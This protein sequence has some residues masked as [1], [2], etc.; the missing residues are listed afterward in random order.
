M[1]IISLVSVWVMPFLIAVILSYGWYRKVPVYETFIEGAK[2][3]FGTVIRI[4]PHLVGMMVAISIF[5]AS[6]AM[7]FIVHLLTPLLNFFHIPAEVVPLALL[8][9]ISGSGSLALMTDLIQ[10]YGPDS[11]IGRLAST[12]Q[13]STDTTLYV[14]TVYFGAIGIR[15]IRYALKVGLM[16]DLVGITAS[17]VIVYLVFGIHS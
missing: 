15:N 6:G 17:I 2:G 14:L 7:D 9:P 10:T 13:G 5:R 3:G 12:M 8:R 11:L 16:A 4:L 1:G